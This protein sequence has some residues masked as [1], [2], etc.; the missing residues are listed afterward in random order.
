MTVVA[1]NLP[2]Y[3]QYLDLIRDCI[4]LFSLEP[5]PPNEVETQHVYGRLWDRSFAYAAGD[6]K[7]HRNHVKSEQWD[8]AVHY[9]QLSKARK[10][11]NKKKEHSIE[12]E[13]TS[14]MPETG[15]DS[16][17]EVTTAERG[18]LQESSAVDDF[19]NSD[20]ADA[21]LLEDADEE[22]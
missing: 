9:D 22:E 20:D 6:D 16:Q 13:T 3:M 1:D 19:E 12:S 15:S 17:P 5:M 14:N 8:A 2:G 7:H 18:Q 21:L 4:T 10:R 11:R